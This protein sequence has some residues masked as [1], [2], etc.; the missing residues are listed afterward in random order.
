[1]TSL[2]YEDIFGYFLGYVSDFHIT[3]LS[4]ENAYELMA[5]YMHKAISKPYMRKIFSTA[6]LDDDMEEFMFE[7]SY[8]TD[9]TADADFVLDIVSKAMVIE[10][11][12]PQVRS[13]IN[14][15]QFFGGREQKWFSQAA[16]IDQLRGLLE[17]TQLEVRRLIRDRGFI[18]NSYLD[19]TL[20]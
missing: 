15:M 7:L 12:Q 2:Q 8:K 18:S 11:L 16:H 1:M 17:D 19:G 6:I 10:W 9:D 20:T 13:K 3:N 4:E 14:T 5:E